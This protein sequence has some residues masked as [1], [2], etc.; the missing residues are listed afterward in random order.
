MFIKYPTI[1]KI[2]EVV[3]LKDDI[4]K[5]NLPG[6]TVEMTVT[7]QQKGIKATRTRQPVLVVVIIILENRARQK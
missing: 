2:R 6:N 1:L 7:F 5:E 4:Q 3:Q